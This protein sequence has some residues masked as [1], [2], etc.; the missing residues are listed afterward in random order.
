MYIE[1]FGIPR[2]RAGVP[3][4]ELHASNLG[5]LLAAVAARLPT[6]AEFI[7]ADRLHS[8][9]VANLNGDHFISDPATPL[10]NDDCVIILSADVGG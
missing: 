3:K 7:T 9:L 4:L 10:V 2:Q 6:L 8:T 5:E 1:F